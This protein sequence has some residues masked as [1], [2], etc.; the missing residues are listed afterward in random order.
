MQSCHRQIL[1]GEQPL[2]PWAVCNL[3]HI[4][5]AKHVV[6]D[7]SDVDWD[8]LSQTI[9]QAV[10]FQDN[11]IDATPYFFDENK[12][13][14]MSERRVG[15]GTLGLAEMLIRLKI[16]YGSSESEK[17]LD[18]LY[19]FIAVR[20]Y[21]TSIN[22]A[23]EKGAFPKFDGDRFI[24]SGFM[25]QMP[26]HIRSMVK[27]FGI[28]NVTIITQAP[29]GTVGTMVGTSTGIEPFFSWSYFRK[30]RL[31]VH[32]EKIQI[33]QDWLSAHPG[34]ELPDYFVHAMQ[35]APEDHVRVQAAIQRWT[36]SA[37]SK[38]CNAPADYTVEQ[39][40]KLYELMYD[41]GCKGGT[42]YRDSSRDEQIL[43]TDIKNLGRDVVEQ[44]EK[45]AG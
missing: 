39:T 43:A 34:Q 33:A 14:Q 31:G 18:T 10:R 21:E 4:N 12:A 2:A 7:D 28:R 19:K 15:M 3:G 6:S 26:E 37:I 27:E 9:E 36:D 23:R 13:Q 40:K 22:L 5:L 20:A 24:E 38:T 42:I 8:K 25:K 44:M 1:V 11:I 30:A 45:K 17:F 35:L 29:T 32:E 41:L 16:K